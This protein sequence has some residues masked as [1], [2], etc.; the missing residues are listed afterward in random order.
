MEVSRIQIILSL[1]DKP[2]AQFAADTIH[3]EELEDLRSFFKDYAFAT[4]RLKRRA[5]SRLKGRYTVL[6]KD[7]LVS[8]YFALEEY[9]EDLE[10]LKTKTTA[11]DFVFECY[12]WLDEDFWEEV[13]I[14]DEIFIL[15][16]KGL[17]LYY[18]EIWL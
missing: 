3:P 8:L 10:F 9:V 13:E 2:I 11:Q 5:S 6:T 4:S 1:H 7:A 15:P 12:H 14:D 18:E 17:K 16:R